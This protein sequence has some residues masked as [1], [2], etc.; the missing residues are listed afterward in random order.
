M[1]IKFLWVKIDDDPR[2]C[3]HLICWDEED[4]SVSH[5]KN[6][7]STFLPR[8][9]VALCHTAKIF[10]RKRFAIFLLW[11]GHLLTFCNSLLFRP[12]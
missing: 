11:Q 2:V 1:R 12:S 10:F 9:I 6:R 4:F 3:D 5:H 7:V 8:F